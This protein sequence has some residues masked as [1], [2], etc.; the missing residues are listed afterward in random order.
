VMDVSMP[1][2]SGISALKILRQNSK[3]EHIPVI[4]LTSEQD[5]DTVRK[6]LT[7]GVTD[8]ITKE[9]VVEI[10]NRLTNYLNLM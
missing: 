10:K 6:I 7:L 9:N 8:Y 3:L 4:M 2:M 1:V 5:V